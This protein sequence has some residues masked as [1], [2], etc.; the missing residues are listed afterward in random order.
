MNLH[1]EK[2]L[3]LIVIKL[4]ATNI[5]PIKVETKIVKEGLVISPPHVF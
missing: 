4:L 2:I 1:V 3:K 5:I